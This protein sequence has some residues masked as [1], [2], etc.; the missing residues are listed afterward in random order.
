MST[1]TKLILYDTSL[2]VLRFT[3]TSQGVMNSFPERTNWGLGVWLPENTGCPYSCCLPLHIKDSPDEGFIRSKLV[4]WKW[5]WCSA[6]RGLG[7]SGWVWRGILGEVQG[8]EDG[9]LRTG[10]DLTD[11]GGADLRGCWVVTSVMQAQAV[12]P[13]S[14]SDNQVIIKHITYQY[15]CNPSVTHKWMVWTK[16]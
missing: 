7:V 9:W 11:E 15:Q 13:V 16:Y 3:E 6:P 14:L 2:L 5:A 1:H 10:P 8:K 12:K 4:G